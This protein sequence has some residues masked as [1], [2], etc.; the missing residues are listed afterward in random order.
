MG[1]QAQEKREARTPIGAYV[2]HEQAQE[3]RE[4]ARRNDRSL[5]AEIRLALRAHIAR[6]RL[7]VETR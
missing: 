1:E 3:I 4:L 2:P 5:S 7:E 6:E